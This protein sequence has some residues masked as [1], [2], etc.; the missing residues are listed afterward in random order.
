MLVFTLL[1]KTVIAVELG[2]LKYKE[3]VRYTQRGF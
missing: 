2:E 3:P 1:A